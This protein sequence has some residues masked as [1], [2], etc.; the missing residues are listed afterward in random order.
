MPAAQRKVGL[1][2]FE[3]IPI[4]LHDTRFASL[5]IGM[6]AAAGGVCQTA[7]IPP[8]GLNIGAY[9]FVA[10]RAQTRL[11]TLVEPHMAVAAIVFI[12]GVPGNQLPGHQHG[13]DIL[14]GHPGNLERKYCAD[15]Q[16]HPRMPR[17]GAHAGSFAKAPC[18]HGANPIE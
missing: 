16:R 17:Y 7:V 10:A 6:A 18:R 11:R 13:F 5:M 14:G 1:V 4:Q 2:M 3:P 9:F 15:Q 8:F 12:L